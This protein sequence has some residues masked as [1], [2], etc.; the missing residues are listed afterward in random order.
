[1]SG[2]RTP[3]VGDVVEGVTLDV[4]GVLTLPPILT[5][6]AAH[7]LE[8]SAN[9]LLVAHHRGVAVEDALLASAPGSADAIGAARHEA[10]AAVAHELGAEGPVGE[11]IIASLVEIAASGA[12]WEVV[13][14][15]AREVIG[16]LTSRGIRVAVV[17]NSN[18]TVADQ[19]SAL[20]ICQVGDGPAAR[21]EAVVDSAVVGVRKP[22][23]AIFDHA[24]LALGTTPARTAH[25]GD[26][27]AFDVLAAERAGL[28]P[29]HYDAGHTCRGTHLH[30][31]RLEDL[32]GLLGGGI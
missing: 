21:V 20:G 8:L 29:V 31:A 17:S 25:V 32:P 2:S 7:G 15:G 3:E 22:D 13:G 28:V 10:F 5:V 27:V 16:H 11:A 30:V 18:G 14:P 24:L 12:A 9:D 4:G 1:V 6:L 19:L 26:T 23:P